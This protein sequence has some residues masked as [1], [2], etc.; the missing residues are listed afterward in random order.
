ME[1]SAKDKVGCAGTPQIIN[2][3]RSL[4]TLKGRHVEKGKARMDDTHHGGHKREGIQVDFGQEHQHPSLPCK[5][6]VV[7]AGHN[8]GADPKA[9]HLANQ[10]DEEPAM[11]AFT[12]ARPDEIAMMIKGGDALVADT[13]MMG[14]QR[15]SKPTLGTNLAACSTKTSVLFFLLSL[16]IGRFCC[17]ASL[18][19]SVGTSRN[20]G[21][22]FFGLLQ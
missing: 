3:P 19:N 18:G 11:V 6:A 2:V 7:A 10:K 22:G 15:G 4:A 14:P 17:A 8:G 1:S 13:A 16:A 21:W 5:I 9:Q 12:D 20:D